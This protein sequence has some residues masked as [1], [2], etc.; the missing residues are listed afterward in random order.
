MPYKTGRLTAGRC[1]VFH[2]RGHRCRP[3]TLH[4]SPIM[5]VEGRAHVRHGTRGRGEIGSISRIGG[6][7]ASE[8]DCQSGSPLATTAERPF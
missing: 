8:G 7:L 6:C 3:A 5:P 2:G 4:L 1:P